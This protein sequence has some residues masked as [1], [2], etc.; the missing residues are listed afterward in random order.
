MLQNTARYATCLF[1]VIGDISL[2]VD[3]DDT[4]YSQAR[5]VIYIIIIVRQCDFTDQM[6]IRGNKLSSVLEKS[7]CDNVAISEGNLY[8][9]PPLQAR[10]VTSNIRPHVT[11]YVKH[12]GAQHKSRQT[13]GYA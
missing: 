11:S 4:N 5:L 2:M 6:N 7:S 8:T 1:T 13:Y 10:S 12:P 9:K 3:I